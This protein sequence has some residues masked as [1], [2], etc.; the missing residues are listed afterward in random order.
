[1]SNQLP[2]PDLPATEHSARLVALIQQEIAAAGGW[3]SFSEYMR[4]ALYAPGLGYYQAG[5]AKFGEQGDFVTAPEI[6]ALFSACLAGQV[7]EVLVQTGCRTVLELGAGSGLMAADM[8]LELQRLQELPQRYLILEP[9]PDLRERQH[10]L[11]LQRVPD[12]L[13]RVVWLDSLPEKGFSGV[14][15]ANEVLDALP[16]SRFEL[17]S[18][19]AVELGIS[20]EGAGLS[21]ASRPVKGA[22]KEFTGRLASM[23]DLPVG[24]RSEVCFAASGLIHS[25]GG[26]LD[27]GAVFLIDYGLPQAEFY[28]AERSDGTLRCH[29]RHHVHNDPL[30]YPGIQ[31]I[32]AWVDFTRV[33][34]A[35]LQA[36]LNVAAYTTQAHFLLHSGIT[37]QLELRQT[38]SAVNNAQMSA[39]V[40]KLTLPGEMG[41]VFKVMLLTTD[42]VLPSTGFQGRD[43]RVNL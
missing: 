19:G 21:V 30:L 40:Q 42:D 17:G 26:F 15:V 23:V 24:Y 8:L 27:K 33:G 13:D 12:L 25:L 18:S 5:A 11:L 1:M 22:L 10:H 31:D 9:S 36:G 39:Q 20:Q 37:A 34:E 41:E 35:A 43:L 14:I 28:S 7:A 6:S 32:T 16:V 29:Y 2:A 3:L 38:D 4:L